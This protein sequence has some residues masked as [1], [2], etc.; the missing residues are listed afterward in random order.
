M[1]N[2]VQCQTIYFRL[3]KPG[4]HLENNVQE[5]V[6]ILVRIGLKEPKDEH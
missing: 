6:V 1:Q 3:Y 2:L 5:V 4:L